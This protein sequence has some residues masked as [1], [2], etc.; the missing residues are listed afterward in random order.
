M[1]S[2]RPSLQLHATALPGVLKPLKLLH[3]QV[4]YPVSLQ[5][6]TRCHTHDPNCPELRPQ[7]PV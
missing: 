7:L 3:M 2:L 4:H 6:P 5:A 1:L